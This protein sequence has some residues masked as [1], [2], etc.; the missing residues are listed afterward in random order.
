MNKLPWTSAVLLL[1]TYITLG[2]LL[3]AFHYPL[4]VWVTIAV[5]VLLL[6][7]SLSSPWSKLR[8]N[9]TRLFKSDTRAFLVAVVAAFVSV[10]IITWLH[11]FVHALVVISAGTLVRLDAQAAGLSQSQTFWLLTI[12][13]LVGL[14]L[15]GVAQQALAQTLI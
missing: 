6:S 10:L 3:S 13:S 8:N 1:V 14:G 9:F 5:G 7:A 11:I 2:W 15:G 4:F 12:V